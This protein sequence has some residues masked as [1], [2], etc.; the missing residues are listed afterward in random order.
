MATT[1]INVR[2][3]DAVKLAGDQAMSTVGFTPTQAIRALWEFAQRNRHDHRKLATMFDMLTEKDAPH[4][5]PLGAEEREAIIEEGPRII[6]RALAD[7]GV[8]TFCPP[9]FSDK[10]FLEDALA[11]DM[12]EKGLWHDEQ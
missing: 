8:E 9:D 1:Q 3:D 6:E 12:E 7:M 11:S 4:D 5:V 10:D 2:I